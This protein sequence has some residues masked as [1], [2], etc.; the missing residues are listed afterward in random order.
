MQDVHSF[1]FG[2]SKLETRWELRDGSM[3]GQSR[4]IDYDKDG[5]EVH[6]TGWSDTGCV[7]Q[8]GGKEEPAKTLLERFRAF[9]SGN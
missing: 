5:N 9:V 2:H 3:H 7:L 8:W 6:D 1:R 4:R